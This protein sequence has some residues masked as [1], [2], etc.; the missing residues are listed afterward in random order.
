MPYVGQNPADIISTAVDT[1]TGAFSGNVTAGGTLGV[2]G[3]VTANAGVVVDNITIDGQEIDVSSGDLNLDV[4]GDINLDTDA[5]EINLK[6]GGTLFGLIIN[7]STDLVIQS[8][9][10]DKDL[11]FKGNDGGAV[12]SALTLDM[13]AGGLAKFN[14]GIAIGGTGA[15]NTLD[16]YEEGTFTPTLALSNATL[17]SSNGTGRYTKIG[18]WVYVEGQVSRA[19]ASGASSGVVQL[20][21]LPFTSLNAN[22]ISVMGSGIM[23]IDEGGPGTGQGD[24]IAFAYVNANETKAV[25]ARAT[26]SGAQT[27]S[28][29]AIGSEFT[30]GRPMYFNFAYTTA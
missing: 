20:E 28:R 27:S 10:Q 8:A 21:S 6:D 26:S 19:T 17:T 5:G 4:A 22:S 29:Y 30:N 24:T 7:S 23:W 9:T 18:R 3:A 14:A 25:P 1:V 16:D 11:I 12:I 2:T 13:S 15:A